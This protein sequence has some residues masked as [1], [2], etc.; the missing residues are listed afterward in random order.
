MEQLMSWPMCF[1]GGERARRRR[2]SVGNDGA[3]AALLLRAVEA[4]E[5][6]KWAVNRSAGA[7]GAHVMAGRAR[8]SAAC[9]STIR[10]PAMRGVH[11]A[12]EP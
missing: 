10:R 3:T 5:W 11:T 2:S 12:V 4:K 6:S 7:W 1:C 8:A 9:G